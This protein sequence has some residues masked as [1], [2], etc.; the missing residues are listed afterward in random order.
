[1]AENF[2]EFQPG[3]NAGNERGTQNKILHLADWQLAL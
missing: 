1:M 2:R 3:N